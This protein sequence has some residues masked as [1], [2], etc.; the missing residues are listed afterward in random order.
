MGFS[1]LGARSGVYIRVPSLR[2]YPHSVIW[3]IP[4]IDHYFTEPKYL[5]CITSHMS[6][7]KNY[8]PLFIK[9][10]CG[11]TYSIL[12]KIDF[13]ILRLT[14]TR[15]SS[16]KKFTTKSF[17]QKLAGCYSVN[18]YKPFQ[19]RLL[20]KPLQTVTNSYKPL[21]TIYS[22]NCYKPLQYHSD[23]TV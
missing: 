10:I 3:T 13:W 23:T 5:W 6:F 15:N 7:L 16:C 12:C 11:Y 2:W 21:Q 1:L 18:C 20:R 22:I 8:I 4:W 17:H 14:P 9:L 19:K